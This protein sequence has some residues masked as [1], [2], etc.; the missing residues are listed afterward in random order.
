MNSVNITYLVGNGFDLM[1]GLKTAYHD[2]YQYIFN[3]YSEDKITNNFFYNQIKDDIYNWSD[4]EYMLGLSTMKR[5]EIE[6]RLKNETSIEKS[7]I[8]K[9]E[10]HKDHFLDSLDEFRDDFG[11]YLIEQQS[12]TRIPEIQNSLLSFILE[13]DEASY[14]TIVNRLFGNSRFTLNFVNFNYTN[15]LDKALEMISWENIGSNLK[16]IIPEFALGNPTMDLGTK[17][18]IHEEVT[19]GMFLGVNDASQLNSEAFTDADLE[20]LIKPRLINAYSY[21]KM[22]VLNDLISKTDI[23]VVFGMSLGD[24]D[25][26]WWKKI[27]YQLEKNERKLVVIHHFDS[28]DLFERSKPRAYLSTVRIIKD[29]LRRFEEKVEGMRSVNEEQIIPIVNSKKLFVHEMV[30]QELDIH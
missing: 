23:F 25:L 26:D 17:I 27:L 29:K 8:G 5:E 22:K 19:T 16:Q 20:Y 9:E 2:F 6:S 30:E 10:F 15:I 13:L 11:K 12:N 21:E 24:T 4:F 1:N 7:N 14:S 18:H 28:S 3:T